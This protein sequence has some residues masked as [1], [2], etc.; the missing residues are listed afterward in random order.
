MHTFTKPDHPKAKLKRRPIWVLIPQKSRLSAGG[1]NH[2]LG[3]CVSP[4]AFSGWKV[5]TPAHLPMLS[6]SPIS[7]PESPQYLPKGCPLRSSAPGNIVH[8]G[9]ELSRPCE[10]YSERFFQSC[11]LNEP[12]VYS[13]SQSGAAWRQDII[14]SCAPDLMV[15]RILYKW[16]DES[17]SFWGPGMTGTGYLVRS[18]P[19]S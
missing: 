1:R 6:S 8:A 4:R 12:W 11:W 16:N 3:D 10:C 18:E 17:K 9:T 15:T 5:F 19:G 14:S 7:S 13:I 2:C